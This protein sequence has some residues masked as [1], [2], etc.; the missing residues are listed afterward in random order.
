MLSMLSILLIPQRHHRERKKWL[1][2]FE[3][4]KRQFR[5]GNSGLEINK[6]LILG[7]LLDLLDYVLM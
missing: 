2:M 7:F 3:Q 5:G 1:V 6:K 4:I